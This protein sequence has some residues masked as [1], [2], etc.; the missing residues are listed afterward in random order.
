MHRGDFIK[1][2]TF[3]KVANENSTSK[4]SI[5]KKLK[6][7]IKV[8]EIEY[9]QESGEIRVKGKNVTENEY[10]NVGQYQSTTITRGHPFSLFKKVWDELSIDGLRIATDPTLTSDLC[11]IVME[12]GLANLFLISSHITT[13]KATVTLSIPK[14]RKGPSQHD[15]VK[16]KKYMKLY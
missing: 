12:E 6:I 4:S 7:T 3:R 13:L 8:E 2:V 15:K 5:K 16:F 14:K 11:A 9:D 10:I 1:T